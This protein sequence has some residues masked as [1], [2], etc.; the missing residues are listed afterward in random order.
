MGNARRP[1]RRL[2]AGG[3]GMTRSDGTRRSG[4]GARHASTALVAQGNRDEGS[5]LAAWLRR[6]TERV[7]TAGS[8]SEALSVARDVVPDWIF[9]DDALPDMSSHELAHRVRSSTELESAQIVAVVDD[10]RERVPAGFDGVLRRPLYGEQLDR[11]LHGGP[12]GG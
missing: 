7:V 2:P 9:V 8:G 6:C 1:A 10:P 5:V 3:R 4:G 12:D 11:L